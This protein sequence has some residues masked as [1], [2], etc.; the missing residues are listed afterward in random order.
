MSEIGYITIC[1]ISDKERS[2]IMKSENN[3]RKLN[4]MMSEMG[5]LYH[6]AA[7]KAGVSDSVH[8]ILY[9]LCA[10]G[11]RCFQ[12]EIYKQAGI[13]RQ[14]I[15]SGIRR[16]EKEGII[17]LENGTGRNTIVCLTEEGIQ[18]AKDKIE[19]LYEIENGIFGEWDPK[20]V[21]TYLN[22]TAKY[23]DSLKMKLK[24]FV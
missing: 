7:V 23:R 14:T 22:L 5:G 13:S 20:D 16:L 19:P 9:V 11:Y 24:H 10:E 21:E 15:N 12:S 2:E 18:F 4:Y 8:S 1:T 17:Y 3:L 6:E